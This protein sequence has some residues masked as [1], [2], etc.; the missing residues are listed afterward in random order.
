MVAVDVGST[1]GEPADYRPGHR[2]MVAASR[3]GRKRLV[4]GLFDVDAASGRCACPRQR[5][6]AC[7]SF[8]GASATG[9]NAMGLHVVIARPED[10][11]QRSAN[12]LRWVELKAVPWDAFSLVDRRVV[13]VVVSRDLVTDAV[14]RM[15]ED[16]LARPGRQRRLGRPP[17]SRTGCAHRGG[18]CSGRCSQGRRGNHPG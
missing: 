12:E 13:L 14:D 2:P 10:L 3:S 16:A 5:V 11:S 1:A 6:L 8:V 15:I 9:G 4:E 7:G 17:R 18:G